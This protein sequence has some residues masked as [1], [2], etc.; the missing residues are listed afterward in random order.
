M[1]LF[2][3]ITVLFLLILSFILQWYVIA[4]L[5]F[6]WHLVRYTRYELVLAAALLDGYYGSFYTFPRLT[7]FTFL[8]WTIMLLLRTRLVLYTR[9]HEMAS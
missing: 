3:R 5:L 6:A 1:P 2:L 4:G 7:I 8:A 9:E